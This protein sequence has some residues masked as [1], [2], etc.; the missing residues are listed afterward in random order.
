MTCERTCILAVWRN[1]SAS[2]SRS[3]GWEFESLCP[4]CECCRSVIFDEVPQWIPFQ[5]SIRMS[6]M[7]PSYAMTWFLLPCRSSPLA[8]A[9]SLRGSLV[10]Y[11]SAGGS[12]KARATWKVRISCL[13]RM[14]A[15]VWSCIMHA[16][17]QFGCRDSHRAHGVVVSHLLSMR[18]A[19]GSIPVAPMHAGDRQRARFVLVFQVKKPPLT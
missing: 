15:L 4:H 5:D 3:E 11:H 19:L 14:C 6:A 13:S 17:L 10:L 9:S 8:L 16:L 7:R 2:D 1:G 12:W 18:E